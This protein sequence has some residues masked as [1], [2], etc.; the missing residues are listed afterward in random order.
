M[1]TTTAHNAPSARPS[2]NHSTSAGTMS[3]LHPTSSGSTPP[4]QPPPPG[5]KSKSKKTPDSAD[6]SK[7]IAAKIAQLESDARGERDQEAEIEAEVRKATREMNNLLFSSDGHNTRAD[8]L[9]KKY[10]ELYT[11][12]KR[13]DREHQKMKK[14]ADNLQREKDQKHSALLK[15]QQKATKMEGLSRSTLAEKKK[16]Q[17]RVSLYRSSSDG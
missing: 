6:A 4:L 1:A 13:A 3:D 10:T 12:M 5:K 7:Q 9:H 2:V 11:E 14:R 15:E 8:I 17:V 16:L